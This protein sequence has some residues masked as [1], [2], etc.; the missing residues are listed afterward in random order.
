MQSLPLTI[1]RQQTEWNTIKTMAKNNNFLEHFITNLKVQMKQ[2]KVHQTQ[3]K[4][5]KNR[6]PSHTTVQKFE[7]SS[8]SSNIPT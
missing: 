4:D 5:K 3:D 8:T 2:Q 1:K 6:Q 7:N